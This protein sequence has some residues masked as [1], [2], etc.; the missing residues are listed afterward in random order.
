MS[1]ISRS[2]CMKPRGRVHATNELASGHDRLHSSDGQE[3]CHF[4]PF[5]SPVALILLGASQFTCNFIALN[6][7]RGY[8][9][10]SITSCPRWTGVRISHKSARLP[11]QTH[12]PFAPAHLASTVGATHWSTAWQQH[13][14]KLDTQL[15]FCQACHSVL[16]GHG[17]DSGAAITKPTPFEGKMALRA[18]LTVP[19]CEYRHYSPC[20]ER[21]VHCIRDQNCRHSTLLLR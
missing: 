11:G 2:L 3:I 20:Q 18:R 14:M 12:S 9:T 21:G 1:S 15:Q 7:F 8:D 5:L 10:T 4:I 16:V 13:G 19:A 17:V 6:H